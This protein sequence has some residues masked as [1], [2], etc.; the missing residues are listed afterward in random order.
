M[1]SRERLLAMGSAVGIF[2]ALLLAGEHAGLIG[3]YAVALAAVSG[4]SFA[5]YASRAEWW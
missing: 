2:A 5:W 3:I 1:S 4:M